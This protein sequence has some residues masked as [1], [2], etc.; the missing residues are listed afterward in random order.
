MTHTDELQVA[1]LRAT[2]ETSGEVVTIGE[3]KVVANVN[4]QPYS[5]EMMEAGYMER[6]PITLE[7][8]KG[9]VGSTEMITP[10]GDTTAYPA[11]FRGATPT[12]RSNCLIDGKARKVMSVENGGGFWI[13]TTILMRNTNQGV[14]VP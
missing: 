2:L 6:E 5:L 9:V 4:R 14:D 13:L 1:G 12:N 11:D 3:E 10:S 8:L 7:I